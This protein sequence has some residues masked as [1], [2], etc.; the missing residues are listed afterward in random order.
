MEKIY[1]RQF[2]RYSTLIK[3][4]MWAM[5]ILNLT[6]APEDQNLHRL[7]KHFDWYFICLRRQMLEIER[8]SDAREL[9]SAKKYSRAN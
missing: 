3:I 7:S 8:E 4:I 1:D 6:L 5:W 2:K 9:D